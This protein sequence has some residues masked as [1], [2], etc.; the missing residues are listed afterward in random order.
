[1]VFTLFDMD[2]SF[3]TATDGPLARYYYFHKI[4]TLGM[5]TNQSFLPLTMEVI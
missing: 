2:T 1:M 3:K 4:L 5:P